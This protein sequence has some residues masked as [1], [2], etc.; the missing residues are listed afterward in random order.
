MEE[1]GV[2]TNEKYRFLSA[3]YMIDRKLYKYYSNSKFAI[4]CIRNRRIHLDDPRTFNDPFDAAFHCAR[5][6]TLTSNDSEKELLNKFLDYL[7][8]VK[9]GDRGIHHQEILNSYLGFLVKSSGTLSNVSIERPVGEVLK[10][11]YSMMDPKKFSIDEFI[12]AIDRGFSEYE[13]VMR[14]NCRISCFSEVCDSILMWSY[15]ANSHNGICIEFDLSLLDQN[16][17]LTHQIIKGISKVH[18][19]PVRADLQYSGSNA[20]GLNF[21][22]SKADVWAHEHEWRL[23]CET[24]MQYLPFDCI[25]GVYIGVNFDIS[26]PKFNELPKAVNTYDSLTIRQCKLSLER[27]QIECE[28]I[29]NSYLKNIHKT[30]ENNKNS[31]KMIQIA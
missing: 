21:L 12:A 24:D 25:S 17:E 4:D 19:T 2:N 3:P 11:I 5:I 1:F 27:Y 26:A 9:K 18:Y 20:S 23:I 7:N 13:R 14:L 10:K 16:A 28:D 15:Y 22:T 31:E 29:Y 30:T 6:S 8:A